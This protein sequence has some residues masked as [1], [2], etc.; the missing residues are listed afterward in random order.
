MVQI[1]ILLEPGNPYDITREDLEP[2]RADIEGATRLNAK[3]A[4]FPPTGA[5]VTLDEVLNIW[6]PGAEFV[7]DEGY[8]ILIG[9]AVEYMRRRFKR[10]RGEKRRKV[11]TIRDEQGREI[12]QVTIEELDGPAEKEDRSDSDGRPRPPTQD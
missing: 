11:I 4:Y 7:R 5:G 12:E 8:S 6:L 9:M 2:L 1:P 10:R 3:V